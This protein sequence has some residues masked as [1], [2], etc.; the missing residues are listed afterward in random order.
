MRAHLRR[1]GFLT[2]LL[3][4]AL[5]CAV[6]ARAAESSRLPDGRAAVAHYYDD[7]KPL[8]AVHC[9][10]CHTGEAAKGGLRLDVRD[11]V[12]TPRK[13]GKT[14]AVAGDS[15]ASEILRRVR[16]GDAEVR[17]PPKGPPLTPQE[18]E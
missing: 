16:S 6:H 2:P 10:K 18:V 7:V 3:A 1:T 13:S 8:L 15:A 5:A 14:A 9:Y 17:M 12:L 4:L 11:S